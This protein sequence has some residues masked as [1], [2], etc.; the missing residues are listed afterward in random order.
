[1]IK[2]GIVILSPLLL[3][4]FLIILLNTNYV[5]LLIKGSY[6][7]VYSASAGSWIDSTAENR[8][9]SLLYVKKI[10]GEKEVDG[11]IDK[12][13][14]AENKNLSTKKIAIRYISEYEK[15]EYIDELKLLQADV[16]NVKKINPDSIWYLSEKKERHERMFYDDFFLSH[17]NKAIEELEEAVKKQKTE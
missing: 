2:K 16:E 8:Y 11:I 6:N 13:T 17:L 5:K 4:I 3:L 14:S 7:F 10:K 15:I 9:V 12:F 1:M